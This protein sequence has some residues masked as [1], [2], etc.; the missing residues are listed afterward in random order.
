MPGN[1]KHG[2]V[3][4]LSGQT[5]KK[6]VKLYVY[7]ANNGKRKWGAPLALS[8]RTSR[9]EVMLIKCEKLFAFFVFFIGV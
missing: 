9:G 6:R 1:E 4:Y 3:I 2:N 5:R 7:M 8:A